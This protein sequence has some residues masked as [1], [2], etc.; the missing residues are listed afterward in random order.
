M[1]YTRTLTLYQLSD[2][3]YYLYVALYNVIYVIPLAVIVGIFT[4]SLGA[5]K[6]TV[7]QGRLLKLLSGV[8]M[9]ELGLVLLI[10]PGWLNN[11]FTGIGLLLVAVMV[12]LLAK[13]LTKSSNQ[14]A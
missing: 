7:L 14:N 6:M 10:N 4:I 11:I 3:D 9:L 12:T 13:W 5:R 2:A 1:V 8:M